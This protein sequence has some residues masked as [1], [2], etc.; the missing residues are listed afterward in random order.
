MERACAGQWF[1]LLLVVACSSTHWISLGSAT[2]SPIRHVSYDHQGAPRTVS[3]DFDATLTAT[4]VSSAGAGNGSQA[5]GIP[6]SSVPPVTVLASVAARWQS[7][8]NPS[9]GVEKALLIDSEAPDFLL[10]VTILRPRMAARKS[11]LYPSESVEYRAHDDLID[12]LDGRTGL[13]LGFRNGSIPY[14]LPNIGK[15]SA[16]PAEAVNALKG[17][18]AALQF[19]LPTGFAQPKAEHN[20]LNRTEGQSSN[21]VDAILQGPFGPFTPRLVAVSS[22]P[23]QRQLRISMM[24]SHSDLRE[25]R[26]GRMHNAFPR[27]ANALPVQVRPFVDRDA[28]SC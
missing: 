15:E 11:P 6:V 20:A 23:E 7:L 2:G 9:P 4:T 12:L 5:G 25:F 21:T 1:L 3:V 17:I 27:H 28:C 16:V 24:A 18:A 10:S 19:R 8:H 13:F 26:P 22:G 14:F